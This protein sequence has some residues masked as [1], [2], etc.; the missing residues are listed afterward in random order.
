MKYLA[1]LGVLFIVIIVV[2]YLNR[3][4]FGESLACSKANEFK[5][6]EYS[7]VV[8]RKFI[9][10]KNHRV[11]T[12]SLRV[13]GNDIILARDTSQLYVFVNVGDSIVKKRNDDYLSLFR[14][15][16]V[17]TFKIYFGCPN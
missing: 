15:S 6:L 13:N 3:D 5:K 16:K 1:V 12:I 10:Q 11:R 14:A 7:G 17:Y 4:S 2:A 8:S 9:D